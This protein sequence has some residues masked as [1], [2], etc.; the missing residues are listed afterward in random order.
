M[1]LL[2]ILFDD[3]HFEMKPY[4]HHQTKDGHLKLEGR[5]RL[6]FQVETA[7][8]LVLKK[9]EQIKSIV[10]MDASSLLQR[11]DSQVFSFE[12]WIIFFLLSS[13][14]SNEKLLSMTFVFILNLYKQL[15]RHF[16]AKKRFRSI[17]QNCFSTFAYFS[18]SNCRAY[19]LRVVNMN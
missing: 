11:G 9:V 19:Y 18:W 15:G 10:S 13:I 17:L 5:E 12:K 3:R 2:G 8:L 4:F 6:R 1:K 16:K 7:M 14:N